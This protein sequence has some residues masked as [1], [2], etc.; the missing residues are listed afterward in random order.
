MNQKLL[1]CVSILLKQKANSIERLGKYCFFFSI[2]SFLPRGGAAAEPK[3]VFLNSYD[4]E[5]MVKTIEITQTKGLRRK[6]PLIVSRIVRTFF[7][8]IE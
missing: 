6:L 2:M 8:L 4:I 5:K 1:M 3:T 7:Y